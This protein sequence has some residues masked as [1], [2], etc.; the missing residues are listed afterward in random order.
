MASSSAST[1]KLKSDILVNEIRKVKCQA[2]AYPS[3]VVHH[4]S[5]PYPFIVYRMEGDRK[6]ATKG[7][8]LELRGILC[9]PI[10]IIRCRVS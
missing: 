5:P 9:L 4:N 10:K 8:A 7:I 2:F 6:E 1:C 3:L